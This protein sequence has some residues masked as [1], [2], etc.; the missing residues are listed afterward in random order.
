VVVKAGK[1]YDASK[2]VEFGERVY[3]T[4]ALADG[5]LYIRTTGHL[6]CFGAK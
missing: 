6:Y 2:P 3:A 4:P 5:R 1:E